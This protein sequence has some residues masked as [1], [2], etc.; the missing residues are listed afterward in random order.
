MQVAFIYLLNT[1]FTCLFF[2][3]TGFTFEKK[4]WFSLVLIVVI[5]YVCTNYMYF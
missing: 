2:P 3:T 5:V 1:L 4:L